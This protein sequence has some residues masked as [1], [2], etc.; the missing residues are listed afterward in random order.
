MTLVR[1]ANLLASSLV[2]P[3]AHLDHDR[4]PVWAAK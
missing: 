2:D 3:A 4:V 1:I